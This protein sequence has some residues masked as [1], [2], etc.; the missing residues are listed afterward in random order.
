ML[1]AGFAIGLGAGEEDISAV[2]C[3]SVIECD[4]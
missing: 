4:Y 2:Y 3:I 1:I